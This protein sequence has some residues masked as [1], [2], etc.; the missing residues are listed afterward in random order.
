MVDIF[1]LPR[2]SLSLLSVNCEPIRQITV[3]PLRFT[4]DLGRKEKAAVNR[5]AVNR[6]FTV[7]RMNY[8]PVNTH[9]SHQSETVGG[10]PR[11]ITQGSSFYDLSQIR[12][13]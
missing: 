9:S 1:C 4:A 10:T 7:L 2:L 5:G 13:V 8:S 12:I 3:K 6:G 11:W